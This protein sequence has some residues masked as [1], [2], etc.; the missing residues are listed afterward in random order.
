MR[1]RG[2]DVLEAEPADKELAQLDDA[3]GD[4]VDRPGERRVALREL[5]VMV[6]HGADA[7]RGR[8]DDHLLVAEDADEAP[9]ELARLGLVAG[10]EVHLSAAR[11]LTRERD[12]MAEPL[13]Q[14]H[15]RDPRLRQQV[16]VGT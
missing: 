14:A 6:A 7:G 9:G 13:E 4:L 3:R 2:A 11:L 8:R 12:L 15:G 1:E 16:S 10:V 5:R